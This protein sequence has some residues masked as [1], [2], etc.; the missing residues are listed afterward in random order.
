[1][2]LNS[3]LVWYTYNGQYI[4]YHTTRP[5]LFGTKMIMFHEM[6]QRIASK[7]AIFLAYGNNEGSYNILRPNSPAPN[8][9][10]VR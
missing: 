5:K 2:E 9:R 10:T 6:T 1:M 3:Q 7:S 4:L 8:G